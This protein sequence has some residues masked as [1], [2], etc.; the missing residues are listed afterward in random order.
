MLKIT[1]KKNAKDLMLTPDPILQGRFMENLALLTTTFDNE[2]KSIE[3]VATGVVKD[4]ILNDSKIFDEY[5]LGLIDAPDDRLTLGQSMF[6]GTPSAFKSDPQD[7]FVTVVAIRNSAYFA[8]RLGYIMTMQ[9]IMEDKKK[10]QKEG[11]F[12]RLRRKIFGPE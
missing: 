3:I 2:R 11:F 12:D 10:P 8:G 4:N 5:N 7:N 9:E 1:F 6:H